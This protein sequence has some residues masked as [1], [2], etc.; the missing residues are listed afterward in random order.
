M[1]VRDL[2]CDGN[3]VYVQLRVF[4]T[5]GDHRD[6]PRRYNSSGCGTAVNFPPTSYSAS[7]SIRGVQVIACVDDSGSNTC[8]YSPVHDNPRT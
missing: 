2:E 7:V 4:Y 6:T 5:E 1:G 8:A 3:D